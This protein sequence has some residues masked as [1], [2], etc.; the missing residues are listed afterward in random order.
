MD[1]VLTG[2]GN[3]RGLQVIAV[4]PGSPAAMA[5]VRRG[6]VIIRSNG[7]GFN[8][9]TTD[10][11]GVN[12]LQSTVHVGG[13]GFPDTGG[14]GGIPTVT[15]NV[16]GVETRTSPIVERPMAVLQVYRFGSLLNL[17]VFHKARE[18]HQ[19]G[20]PTHFLA[21]CFQKN[22]RAPQGRVACRLRQSVC[23]P[24]PRHAFSSYWILKRNSGRVSIDAAV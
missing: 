1:V 6:D 17:T 24:S 16:R 7:Q 15:T 18:W 2:N 8:R 13:G 20:L 4:M 23:R 9:A 3:T 19:S 14:P 21:I 10:V 22:Q 5:G 11:Q 12:I